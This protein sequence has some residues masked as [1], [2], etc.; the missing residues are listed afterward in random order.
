MSEF[1]LK[2]VVSINPETLPEDTPEDFEFRYVD[3][4]SVGRGRL[5]EEPTVTK[6]GDAPSRARRVLR[7]G[8]TIVSTVRTYLRAVLP[9]NES[10]LVGSTG[11]ACLR[12]RAGVLPRFLGWWAQSDDF[13]K[14]VVARSV[15]V[16]YPAINPAEIGLMRFPKRPLGEQRAISH[17]LDTETARIDSLIA[18]KQRMESLLEERTNRFVS[19]ITSG[20]VEG[21]EDWPPIRLRYAVTSI[22]DS[23]HSTAPR[24]KGGGHLVVRTAAVK[25]GRLVRAGA[26]ETDSASYRE[27]TRR[28]RPTPGDVL[29]T[30][31]APA[32]EACLVPSEPPVCLG[33]RMVL[34]KV[35]PERLRGD[36]LLH[37]LYSGPAQRFVELLSQGSTVA[38]LNMSDIR[39]I[40][41]LLP[42][43]EQQDRWLEEIAEQVERAH[44]L[45]HKLE[46]QIELLQEHRQA[47]IT[48]AVTGELEVPGVAA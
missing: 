30:R 20:E 48:A 35:D 28:G 2:R 23:E 9:V 27:W 8:D 47:L 12:P 37:S 3:I 33:Q 4:G 11:F 36:W 41:L 14:E 31:E 19:H 26:Y 15:G 38:H 18:K 10:G 39:D 45:R 7:Q 44:S 42:P 21:A 16:S 32:G 43:I 17:F 34:F 13:I 25:S 1:P 29:F 22:I 46:R 24:V 6:F 5:V 40:P